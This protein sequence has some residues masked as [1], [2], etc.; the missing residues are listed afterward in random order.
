MKDKQDPT[1]ICKTIHVPGKLD[2]FEGLDLDGMCVP[3]LDQKKASAEVEEQESLKTSLFD[4]N[5]LDDKQLQGLSPSS[6]PNT[7]ETAT[8]PLRDALHPVTEEDVNFVIVP[9][10]KTVLEE[11]PEQVEQSQKDEEQPP[12]QLE[13]SLSTDI[14]RPPAKLKEYFVHPIL[15]KAYRYTELTQIRE[16]ILAGLEASGGNTL[17]I[18]SPMDNTG[19]SLLTAAL[20][21]NTARSCQKKVLLID[22]NMRRAGLHTFFN[23]D[24]SYG[25]TELIQ[26]NM[27]WQAVTKE[28][29]IENLHVI[30]A[31]TPCD[32]FSEY[33]RHSHIPNLIEEMRHQFDLIIF[34][35]SPILTPNRNNVNIVSLTSVVDYFLLITKKAGT[36]KDHLKETINVIEAGNGKID[37]IVLNEHS[38]E[39][40]E[41]PYSKQA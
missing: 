30:T 13:Q 29:G 18:A 27:P 25:F 14:A 32:T 9:E 35:T 37:G 5:P 33:L 40:K 11:E 4:L 10:Q 21:Y 1:D 38:P 39:K 7:Q 34:D 17:L 28:T 23:L 41:T 15:E 6:S 19:S 31:G 12:I 8:E 22:C 36:T 26:K 2:P 24:Q 16:K 3:P 20:G